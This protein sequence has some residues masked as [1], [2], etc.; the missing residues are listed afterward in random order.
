LMARTFSK[1]QHF[2]VNYNMAERSTLCGVHA[3]K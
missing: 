1:T 3:I 2:Q